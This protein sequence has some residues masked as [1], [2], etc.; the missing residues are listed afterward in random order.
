MNKQ[1][2][3]Y[4]RCPATL[5][6]LRLKGELLPEAGFFRVSPDLTLYGRVSAGQTSRDSSG[7]LDDV[8]AALR[9]EK[10]VCVLPFD[11]DEVVDNL[12]HERYCGAMPAIRTSA[13]KALGRRTYYAMRPFLPT[14]VR[15]HLQRVAFRGWDR[16]HFPGWPIDQTV[17]RLFDRMMAC[18]IRAHSDERIPFIWF[19][20]DGYSG[21]A[22][23]THDVETEAGRDFCGTLMDLDDA[24]GIKASFQVVPEGRYKV[25][26][27]FLDTLRERGFE[28][29]VHDFNHDGDLF[30][31]REEFLRRVARINDYGR[32]FRSVGYRSAVLYRNLEWYEFFD[33][34]YDMSVPNVGHLDPQRG[35]CCTTKPY[36]IGK[37]LEI[38]VVATQDYTLFN[39]LRQYSTDLWDQQ[40]A[41]VLEHNGLISFI[42]HPDYL[43]DQ[44]AREVYSA[45]LSS[46]A[47]LRSQ[48]KLWIPLHG[49]LTTGG[50][51]ETKCAWSKREAPG[52]LMAQK[53]GAPASLTPAWRPTAS[54]TP[55]ILSA[56]LTSSQPLTRHN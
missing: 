30:R 39:I 19:W 33:Y 6:D 54:F 4:F 8:S 3:E 14:S 29:N 56:S 23:M 40:I 42:V 46:L 26:D 48:S 50:G 38:P 7:P 5:V 13:T 11:L 52:K 20:P 43:F 18:V 34:S 17:D 36:F 31:D 53:S 2:L 9:V 47:R 35:G 10:N 41:L 21:C 55:S 24:F 15:K 28:L 27:E 25:S 37:I 51:A 12:R 22:T 49:I 44:R 16:A 32:K 1:F 45:L